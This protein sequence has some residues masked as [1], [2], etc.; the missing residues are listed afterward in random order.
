[1]NIALLMVLFNKSLKCLTSLA[2]TIV[3]ATLTCKED[4]METNSTVTTAQ[5]I[6]AANAVLKNSQQQQIEF[7]RK[8][9]KTIAHSA[10]GTELGKGDGIDTSA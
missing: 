6:E 5:S 4:C 7:S 8:V 3:G 9:L 2:M 10:V 1:V